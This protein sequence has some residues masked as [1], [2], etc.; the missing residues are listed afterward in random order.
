[1]LLLVDKLTIRCRT[2]D[3]LMKIKNFL[4]ILLLVMNNTYATSKPPHLIVQ[5]VVDQLRGD[6]IHQYQPR[7]SESGFNYLLNHGIEFSNAHHPHANT[8]TCAGHATIATG[9]YPSFHGIINNDWYDRNTKELIYCM[10]DRDSPSLIGL[11][12]KTPTQGRSPKNLAASTTSDELILAQKGRAFAVSLKDRA[13]IALAG[14]AGKAFWFDKLNGGFI[15]SDYYYS[16]YPQWVEQWN[17]RYNPQEIIWNLSQAKE[18]YLNAQTPVFPQQI[19]EFRETFPHAITMAPSEQYFKLLSKTPIADQ[20]TADFAEHL[21]INEH[22]GTAANKTD[23]LGISFS[24]VDA[25]GHQFGP[26]SLEAEDNLLILDKTIAHLLKTIDKQVGLENT[27]IIITADHGVADNPAYLQRHHITEINPLNEKEITQKINAFLKQKYHLP[28][29]TLSFIIPPY[30]YLNHELI[31]QHEQNL[32]TITQ[33]IATLLNHEEGLFKAYP[34]PVSGVA[35]DWLSTKVNRMAYPYRAGDI[36]LVAP[37][38]QS[39]GALNNERVTHGSPW[40]YDSYVPLLFVNPNFTASTSA[41]PVYTTDIAPTLSALLQ[42]KYPSA[43]VG[44][45]L[46]ELLEQFKSAMKSD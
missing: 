26:N 28:K 1:M 12:T 30:I 36:Y 42:I 23:Y 22:L 5:I 34:L 44:Q 37:P 6:L 21:L 13:A 27:L 29:E 32:V 25:I 4:P 39:K 24:A 19:K 7:F 38:Y 2:G 16:T 46:I 18:S 40:S 20:L 33:N 41:R 43:T 14:H 31:A 35:K 17:K 10:E 8:T 11:R 45:P 15:T 9:S 3:V